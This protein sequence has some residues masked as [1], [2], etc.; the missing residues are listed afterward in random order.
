MAGA[1]ARRRPVSA[2]M[3]PDPERRPP[4]VSRRTSTARGTIWGVE[5]V[6]H[7]CRL[8]ASE[9]D[10]IR[11]LARA[12]GHDGLVVH[13]S[14]A[15]T[16]EAVAAL[17]RA[18][19]RSARERPG[20]RIVVT[21]CAAHTDGAALA[22]MPE[23]TAVIGN[24]EKLDAGSWTGA[25]DFGLAG[26]ER[27]RVAPIEAVREMAPH[28]AARAAGGPDGRVRAFLAVQNGCDHA[29]TFC[30][31]PKGRGRAR[32]V[33]MGAAV[34]GARRLAGEGRSEIVLTGVDLTSWGGDLPGAPRLGDLVQAILAHVPDLPRL[35][36]SS[37]DSVEADPALM[38]ALGDPRL[39]PHM[40]LSL[41]HGHDLILKRMKRRHG[42]DDA[43]RI[44]AEMRAR[45]P[46][47]ALGA[48][49]I[50]GFPTETDAHHAASLGLI[51]ACGLV[52]VHVFPFSPREGTPAA[53]MPPVPRPVARAR[54]AEL[55][56]AAKAGLRAH[57]D[58]RIGGTD[59]IVVHRGRTEGGER[60]GLA[61][62]FCRV[63]LPDGRGAEPGSRIE[64]GIVARRGES[65]VARALR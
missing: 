56:A 23:V 9:S 38:D 49:L 17:R 29:C 35:R 19:R 31:I 3:P 57:L 30:I 62:D 15:V 33:P 25:P 20:A 12:A 55:R 47:I 14:C 1:G 5:V 34:E 46:D 41:Q 27:L 44:C 43:L 60:T 39:M 7:G 65:L 13:N 61:R 42:R 4:A 63:V 54:A 8:N 6:T 18:I 24:A 40:H 16:G 64:V 59:E 32:S 36:L 45:R 50:A 10:E 26:E 22:A 21:G 48:D 51:E 11:A 58:A 28:M 53:R 2:S 37:I 52:H